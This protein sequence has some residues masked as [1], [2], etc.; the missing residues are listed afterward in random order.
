MYRVKLN[1]PDATTA[2]HTVEIDRF[3]T[4]AELRTAISR[5]LDIPPDQ[6]TMSNS[7]NGGEFA[8]RAAAC[9]QLDA[10]A[11]EPEEMRLSKQQLTV[12]LRDP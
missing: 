1:H 9:S 4:V 12:V 11:A 2:T 10:A 8:A 5:A 7:V 3:C 6:F